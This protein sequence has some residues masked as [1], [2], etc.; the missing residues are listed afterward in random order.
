MASTPARPTCSPSFF[1][2]G[3]KVIY[4]AGA[5]ATSIVTPPPPGIAVMYKNN[6]AKFLHSSDA[7]GTVPNFIPADLAA[8][9]AYRQL[10][11]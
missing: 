4:K 3:Y 9:A 6:A 1:T 2:T 8:G 11:P 5:S 7:V 10:T